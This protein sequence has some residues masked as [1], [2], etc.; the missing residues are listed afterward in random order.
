MGVPFQDHN[1][2][3]TAP[4]PGATFH[5]PQLAAL[6]QELD[7]DPEIQAWK[8]TSNNGM[9]G[10]TGLSPSAQARLQAI[11]ARLPQGYALNN[12][13]IVAESSFLKQG[14][15]SLLALAGPVLGGMFAGGGSAAGAGASG[16]NADGTL[17]S[18]VIAPTSAALPAGTNGLSLAALGG[19]GT[20]AV[21]TALNSQ[22][23]PSALSSL[24]TALKALVPLAGL[25]TGHV[26]AGNQS[27]QNVP[28]QLNDLLAQALARIKY[29]NPLFQAA[30][31]QALGGL[32]TYAQHGVTPPTG[33]L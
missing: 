26:I 8:R 24:P 32:P 29:Q 15:P 3:L 28:P 9:Y 31:Q 5:D 16:L 6:Q 18:H 20:T 30:T 25:V 22:N 7:S 19:T 10:T 1:P 21:T 2:A 27:N 33:N 23:A 13:N 14:L 17:A 12:G 11:S 4:T